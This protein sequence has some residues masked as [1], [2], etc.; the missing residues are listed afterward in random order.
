[1]RQVVGQLLAVIPPQAVR[2]VALDAR[3]QQRS[4][5]ADRPPS[6]DLPHEQPTAR[7]GGQYTLGIA[8]R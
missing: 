5:P 2:I 8:R 4:R 1:V 3:M 7:S 6:A